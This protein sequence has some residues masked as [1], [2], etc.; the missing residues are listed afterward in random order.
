MYNGSYLGT[1]I[2]IYRPELRVAGVH[3]GHRAINKDLIK[4]INGGS[5]GNLLRQWRE[6]EKKKHI[7][8]RLMKWDRF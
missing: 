7:D 8:L 1:C 6:K 3:S 2:I 5:V 4:Q